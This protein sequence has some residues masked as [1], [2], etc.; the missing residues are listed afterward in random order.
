MNRLCERLLVEISPD[1]L[2]NPYG[3]NGGWNITA[4][5]RIAMLEKLAA[6]TGDGRYRFGA[7]KLFNYLRFQ[8]RGPQK[9]ATILGSLVD[10]TSL[11]LGG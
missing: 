11:H 4:D 5:Y 1:G 9:K 6:I 3:P 8:H 10:S 7:Q 2:I